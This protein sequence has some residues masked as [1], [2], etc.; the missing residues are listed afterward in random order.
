MS[1]VFPVVLKNTDQQ[2]K[3]SR[4][5]LGLNPNKIKNPDVFPKIN[6]GSWVGG[7]RDG[8]PFVTPAVTKETLLLHRKAALALI[9]EELF[10]LVKKTVYFCHCQPGS[11][12]TYRGYR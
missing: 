9:R 10:Y 6:F 11:F 8:H 7:D 3:S 5:T 4:I 1:K 12:F 2:L